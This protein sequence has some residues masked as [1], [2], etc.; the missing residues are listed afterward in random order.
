MSFKL[1]PFKLLILC[2]C[3][4]F[5]GLSA[6]KIELSEAM[7]SNGDLLDEDL[8]SPD[9]FE[10]FNEGDEPVNL[11]DWSITDRK[12]QVQKWI[13]PDLV[14]EP[15]SYKYLWASAKDRNQVGTRSYIS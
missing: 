4:A 5:Q 1:I 3:L 9:W 13:F 7:P 14:M 11:K 10:L 2:L 8:D 12:D 15:Y 6:Q